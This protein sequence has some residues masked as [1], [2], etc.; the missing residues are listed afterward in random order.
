[1][2]PCPVYPGGIC[3]PALYMPPCPVYASLGVVYASLGEVY[4]PYPQGGI[5]RVIHPYHTPQGAYTGLYTLCT[6]L[7]EAYTGLFPMYTPLG[8]IYRVIHHCYTP[9]GGIYPGYTPFHCWS[10]YTRVIHPFHCWRAYIRVIHPF[11]CWAR[12]ALPPSFSRFTVG[13]ER[14]ASR[15]FPFHCWAR[16]ARLPPY[17]FHC[18]A[19]KRGKAV[20]A[21]QDP[22]KE[23]KRS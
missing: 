16:N 5:Y 21:S 18:W 20:L 14:P 15:P 8:G 6:P 13:L 7:R 19:R 10:I 17:P 12:K 4:P 9:L 11:H 3:L 22:M 23:E 2:P 1:M